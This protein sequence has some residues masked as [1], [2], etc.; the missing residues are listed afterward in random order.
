MRRTVLTVVIRAG[1]WQLPYVHLVPGALKQCFTLGAII[2]HLPTECI[3][4]LVRACPFRVRR[5]WVTNVPLQTEQAVEWPLSPEA[6]HLPVVPPIPLF[7]IVL[8]DVTHRHS[9]V[10]LSGYRGSPP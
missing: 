4:T 2:A 7:V 8:S 6:T 9:I 3:S 10:S 1:T 5:T